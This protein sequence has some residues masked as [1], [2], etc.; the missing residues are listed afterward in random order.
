MVKEG[1]IGKMVVIMKE[2]LLTATFPV[3]EGTTLQIWTSI[4]KENSG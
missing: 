2:T 4:M 3:S 1:S